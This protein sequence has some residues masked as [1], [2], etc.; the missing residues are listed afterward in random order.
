MCVFCRSSVRRCGWSKNAQI[1]SVR[2]YCQHRLPHGVKRR[3]WAH[4]VWFIFLL[5]FIHNCELVMQNPSPL[6]LRTVKAVGSRGVWLRLCWT[7]MISTKKPRCMFS[8]ALIR[9]I[10]VCLWWA[11][12]WERDKCLCLN[13]ALCFCAH[14]CVCFAAL[15]IH[16]SSATKEVLDEFCYFNLEL[17]GDVEMKV[18][19]LNSL[20]DKLS[21]FL[22]K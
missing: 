8:Q 7:E 4:D 14:I 20:T 5:I 15:K 13:S 21:L 3:R 9:C 2:R 16:V 12:L 22:E 17:R 6:K 1:L 18:R 19:L 10:D 11:A